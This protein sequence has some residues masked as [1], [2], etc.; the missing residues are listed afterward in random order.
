MRRIVAAL[1]LPLITHICS[2]LAADLEPA[3]D[4]IRRHEY[5]RAVV[6]LRPLSEAGDAEASFQ[7]SQLFRYG[8]GVAR[9]LPQA[10]QLLEVAAT[11]GHARAAGGLAAMLESG[12]C[13]KSARKAE[14]WR[15]SA[16]SAGYAP[17]A[18]ST[19]QAEGT[20]VPTAEHLLRAVRAGDLPL[21]VRL[22]E[23]QPIDVTDEYGRTPVM[24]AIEA[25]HLAVARELVGR[26]ASL[27]KTDRSGETPL[28]LAARSGDKELLSLLLDRGA[29]VDAAN[30]SG[31]TPLMVAALAGSRELC[32][33]LL[34]AGAD[35]GLRDAG[36]LRAGDHAA[37]SRHA[38]LALRLGV[39]TRRTSS[40]PARSSALNAGQT[41]L[42]L[43]AENGDVALLG[44]RLAAGDDR[45]AADAQG[46]TALA[47]A[48]RA[49]KVAAV[50]ALLAAG[51]AV[52]VRDR[53][54]STALG[55]AI[56]SGEIDAARRLLRG[57]A[58]P[59]ARQANGKPPLLIAIVSRSADAIRLL[60]GAGADPDASDDS[61]M[62]PL[63][64]AASANNVEAIKILLAA[65][66][67]P[68]SVDKHKRTAL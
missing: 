5:E 41:M 63:M 24:L 61:G 15:A 17:P 23:S 46:M 59:R 57:G 31:T 43:A 1:V 38:D 16:H 10:C 60:L 14:E 30:H 4:A 52:D 47:F 9:D 66:A 19:N 67:R 50:E 3:R 32:D 22:L 8:R 26:G 18:A 58:D 6:L 11:A 27:I 28:L 33:R 34:A 39:D 12:E 51:A 48:A 40:G 53:A 36:G 25:G 2:A 37:R 65:G 55:Q 44:Q 29:P 68:D 20:A 42:M 64:A 21:V 45:N 54:G 56:R 13:Q 49:G 35:P 62:T 7:L